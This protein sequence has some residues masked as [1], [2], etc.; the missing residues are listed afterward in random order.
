MKRLPFRLDRPWIVDPH[1]T[2]FKK[3]VFDGQLIGY[4]ISLDSQN[5]II[6]LA[7]DKYLTMKESTT[8]GNIWEK[9]FLGTGSDPKKKL[10][11]KL[12]NKLWN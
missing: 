10:I 11:T 9:Y 1:N 3:N 5:S 4:D 8:I 6:T 12:F 7:I 2:N